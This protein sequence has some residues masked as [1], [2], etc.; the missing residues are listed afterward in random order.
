V[1]TGASSGIGR[2]FAHQLATS[3]ID[4]VL[5]ARRVDKLKELGAELAMRY[6]AKFRTVG[7][8]L[9]EPGFLEP[10]AAATQDLDVG[11][12]VSNAGAASPGSLLR[13]DLDNER[14]IVA[15]NT[16]AH[17][18]LTHHFA[19]RLAVRGR[20]G[21]LL[22]SALGAVHGVPY[23]ANAAATKAY[24]A[25]LGAGLH[26]ELAGDGVNVCVLHPGPTQTPV[27]A[28]LGLQQRRLFIPA[29]P[30][31]RC[32]AEALK[33]IEHNRARCIPG[34]RNRIMAAV[35]PPAV[36]RTVMARM[37]SGREHVGEPVDRCDEFSAVA[38]WRRLIR[39]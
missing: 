30:V 32:V 15:L 16:T 37:L 35:T 21:I 18:E 24:V 25:S 33:A 11:L 17:L 34:R 28:E 9:S 5:V 2:Q 31:E 4:V 36:T 12:L 3:G 29:M 10:I 22:V 19:P 38:S 23:M 13:A 39:R 7:V 14:R 20:G 6:L 26:V 27:L 8:D 1:V